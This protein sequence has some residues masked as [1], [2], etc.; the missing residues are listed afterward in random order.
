MNSTVDSSIP[1]ELD[2][3]HDNPAVDFL[4]GLAIILAASVLNAGGLNIT[5]LDHIRTSA[6]PKEARRHDFLRPLWVTGMLLYILSQLIGSTLALEY[7]RAGPYSSLY[8][9]STLQEYV[10]PLGSTSLIFNFLFASFIGIPVSRMDIYGTIVVVLGV[11]GIVAFGSI[12]SGLETEL[13]LHRLNTMWARPGWIVYF[14]LMTLALIIVYIGS[15]QLE[16]VLQARS[17]L[18][19]LPVSNNP[20]ARRR[21]SVNPDSAGFFS[22]NTARWESSMGWLREK[23]DVWTGAKDDKYVAWML[24][25]GWS[26]NGGGLAGACLIFAKAT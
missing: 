25:I 2:D 10:A 6:L 13:D 12:N 1:S 19:S 3:N 21:G 24:G 15:S 9:S 5:K 11:V 16:L 7:M 20:N 4:I 22:R 26:C 18:T 8:L 23:L 14:I 17:D